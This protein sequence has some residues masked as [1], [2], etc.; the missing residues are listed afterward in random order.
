MSLDTL[1]PPPSPPAAQS[2]RP[3]ALAAPEALERATD[4]GGRP[5]P[6]AALH[7]LSGAT[8]VLL[9]L[10]AVGALLHH[11]VLIPP[12]AASAALIHSS[13]RLP[14]SQPRS[15][16][17]GHILAALTGFAVHATLGHSPWAAAVAGGLAMGAMMLAHAPHSPACATAVIVVLQSPAPVGF[18][19]LLTPAVVLLVLAGHAAS[20]A[21][22]RAARYPA[23]WW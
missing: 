18:L 14:L 4:R 23:Y 16:V 7:S 5:S 1:Q 15:V 6:G 20:R 2:E 12:L 11:P 3:E 13:P 17:G 21:H 22:P 10:A 9:A 19:A 8:A